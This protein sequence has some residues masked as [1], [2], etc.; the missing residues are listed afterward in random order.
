MKK[1]QAYTQNLYESRVFRFDHY[2]ICPFAGDA[3][4]DRDSCLRLTSNPGIG[5]AAGALY[6]RT[7]GTVSNEH[8]V[9]WL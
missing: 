1:V 5:S 8:V 6:N 4:H 3:V 7:K 9:Y 2:F